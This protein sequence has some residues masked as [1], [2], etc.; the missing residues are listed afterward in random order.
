MLPRKSSPVFCDRGAIYDGN[1]AEWRE[2]PGK[3]R[4]DFRQSHFCDRGVDTGASGIARKCC[5]SSTRVKCGAKRPTRSIFGVIGEVN[6]KEYQKRVSV[7]S[8]VQMS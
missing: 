8:D 5:K 4:L 2:N 1:Q 3:F 6:Q 7:Q